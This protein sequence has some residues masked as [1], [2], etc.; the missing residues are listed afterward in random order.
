MRRKHNGPIVG[1]L[2]ELV[3]EDGAFGFESLDDVAIVHD[4]VA[5]ID[6]PSVAL[7][8]TLDDLDGALDAGAEAARTGEQDFQRLPAVDHDATLGLLGVGS[9][10]GPRTIA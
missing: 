10:A 3:D 2:V 6:R 5:H 7:D 9:L 8:G 4:L 1:H